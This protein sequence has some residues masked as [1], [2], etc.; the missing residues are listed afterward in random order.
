LASDIALL[1]GTSCLSWCGNVRVTHDLQF[2]RASEGLEL[3]NSSIAQ[4]GAL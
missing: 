3:E 2:S 4:L 1:L